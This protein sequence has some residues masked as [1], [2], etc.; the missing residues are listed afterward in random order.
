MALSACYQGGHG[1]LRCL[2]C[3]TLHGSDPNHQLKDG[4]RTN[5]ACYG[6]HGTYRE[7]LVE[8]THHAADSSGSLC[9]NCHMPYQVYSL[10]ATQRSHRIVIPRVRDS[11]GTGKPHAC[12]LCHLDKSLGWTQTQLAKWPGGAK[13]RVKLSD[14]EEK[15]S[16]AVL[17]M[18]T[19]DARSRALFVGA[20]ANP[21]AQKASGTDWFG[22]F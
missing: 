1:N 18:T 14:D 5:E 6:C 21:A 8:H 11:L 17:M 16:S 10:L 15:I 9:T 22:P 20:F 3:H 12:N 19:G 13:G 4:M 7:R 2:T